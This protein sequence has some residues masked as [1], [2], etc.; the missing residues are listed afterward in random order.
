[1]LGA[2]FSFCL[3]IF[4]FSFVINSTV[5]NPK[6]VNSWI[7]KADTVDLVLENAL[8]FVDDIKISDKLITKTAKVLKKPLGEDLLTPQLTSV[9]NQFYGWLNADKY[10]PL[11]LTFDLSKS[12]RTITALTSLI[13]TSYKDL[14]K[15]GKGKDVFLCYDP[16]VSA[17]QL[18]SEVRKELIGKD[19]ALKK[20]SYKTDDQKVLK[21]VHAG[22]HVVS[23]LQVWMPILA[24]L[25]GTGLVY[26]STSRMVGL[27]RL[28]KFA[29]GTFAPAVII[30]LLVIS[31]LPSEFNIQTSLDNASAEAAITRVFT[32]L[33]HTMIT[34]I[35]WTYIKIALLPLIVAV[36]GWIVLKKKYKA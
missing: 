8:Y 13:K 12:D 21:D 25:F 23:N 1:M 5:G 2:M 28:C 16:K 11:K 24:I 18:A 26:L 34:A 9:I 7:K 32:P 10:R 35:S 15:C 29:V 20:Y 19:S 6:A 30:S 27:K 3:S 33:I 4:L 22:R 36:G 14:S 17:S 31:F